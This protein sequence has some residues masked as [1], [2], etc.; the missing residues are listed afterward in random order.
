MTVKSY[1]DLYIRVDGEGVCKNEYC[2]NEVS[3]NSLIKGYTG[4]GNSF[5]SVRCS[6]NSTSTIL[7]RQQTS[8]SIYGD[9][10]YRNSESVK[11]T[12]L[13][14]YGVAN[15]SLVPTV[16]EKKVNKF[17][18]KYGIDNPFESEEIKKIIRNKNIQSG[19]WLSEDDYSKYKNYYKIVW[20][21]TNRNRKKLFDK[22]DGYDYYDNEFILNQTIDYNSPIYPSIDHKISVKYGF[23]NGISPKEISSIDNLCITKRILNIKKGCMSADLFISKIGN[24]N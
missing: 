7:K 11:K 14:K 2:N 10:N 22:W 8:L 12:C 5:C 19:R 3:F 9:M 4:R 20:V 16:K 17:R 24:K 13:L 21:Y 1:Y 18:N 6:A 23:M 15:I